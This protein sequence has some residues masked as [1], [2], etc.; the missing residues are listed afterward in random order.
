M[1]KERV[2]VNGTPTKC[3]YCN[4]VKTGWR[5]DRTK[6]FLFKFEGYDG[7]YCCIGCMKRQHGIKLDKT[8]DE[9]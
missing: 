9:R 4:N 3:S 6:H 8:K 1:N 5:G 7:L 2:F